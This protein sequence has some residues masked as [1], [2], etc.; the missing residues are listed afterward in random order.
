[1]KIL[2]PSID[3][4]LKSLFGRFSP[5]RFVLNYLTHEIKLRFSDFCPLFL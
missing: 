2:I 3:C 5:K 1:M 4:L